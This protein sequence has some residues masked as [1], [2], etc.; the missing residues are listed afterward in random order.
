MEA[1]AALLASVEISMVMVIAAV[2]W[3]ERRIVGALAA[4]KQ[5]RQGGESLSKTGMLELE[6]GKNDLFWRS[7]AGWR[8]IPL[9]DRALA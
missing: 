4:K 9:L 8:N 2:D 6:T 5:T 1:I 7:T 3:K